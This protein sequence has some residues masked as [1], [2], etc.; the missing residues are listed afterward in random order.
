MVGRVWEPYRAEAST[1]KMG[2]TWVHCFGAVSVNVMRNGVDF[3]F[4]CMFFLIIG[5][6]F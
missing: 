2:Y 3:W 5:I 1:Q 4:L 6:L